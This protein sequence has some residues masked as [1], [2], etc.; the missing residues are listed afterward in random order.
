M[1]GFSL[2]LGLFEDFSDIG[3]N[4]YLLS[5]ERRQSAG[6]DFYSAFDCFGSVNKD[7]VGPFDFAQTSSGQEIR[8][9]KL[10]VDN[11]NTKLQSKIFKIFQNLSVLHVH[12]PNLQR[13]YSYIKD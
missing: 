5:V 2:L 11:F 13:Y 9:F 7:L 8:I 3:K 4:A 6:Q 12:Q 1:L 10:L